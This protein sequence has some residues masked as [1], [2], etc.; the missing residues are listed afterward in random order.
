VPIL[1]IKVM[2]TEKVDKLNPKAEIRREHDIPPSTLHTVLKDRD[3]MMSAYSSGKYSAE[4]KDNQEAKLQ[5][6]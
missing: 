3:N 1:E 2:L 6:N 5:R 4:E